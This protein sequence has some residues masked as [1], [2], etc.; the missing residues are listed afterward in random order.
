MS[1]IFE[2]EK[3]IFLDAICH[4]IKICKQNHKAKLLEGNIELNQAFLHKEHKVKS[5]NKKLNLIIYFKNINKK[6]NISRIKMIQQ[7][8]KYL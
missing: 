1:D 2:K 3:K 7:I 8:E 4:S 5:R 6:D